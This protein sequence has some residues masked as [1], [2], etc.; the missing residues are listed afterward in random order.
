M[1]GSKQGEAATTPGGKMAFST[2]QKPSQ[3]Q[4]IRTAEI[5]PFAGPSTSSATVPAASNSSSSSADVVSSSTAVAAAAPD[6]S[7]TRPRR[8]MS[9]ASALVAD[10]GGGAP[11]PPSPTGSSGPLS[12]ASG[13]RSLGSMGTLVKCRFGKCVYFSA[14][15]GFC[16]RHA[17]REKAEEEA[18]LLPPRSKECEG[19]LVAARELLTT[20]RSY[21]EALRTIQKAFRLRL[22]VALE[23]HVAM[24]KA[25]LCTEDDIVKIFGNVA[26]LLAL[27]ESL[28]ADLAAL[29]EN[30]R[31]VEFSAVV[32]A[33][34]IPQFQGVYIV[35]LEG[36]DESRRRLMNLRDDN[37]DFNKFIKATEKSE[38]L[39]LDS[40]LVTPVQ[41]LPRSARRAPQQIQHHEIMLSSLC[42][43]QTHF[44]F[45]CVFSRFQILA[46]AEGVD[47]SYPSVSF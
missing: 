3:T 37:P 13:A 2:L 16:L 26:A 5:P 32:L 4:P 7:R 45:L 40:F 38:G 31:S 25:P 27:S 23:M 10:F 22:E 12:P 8:A 29:A 28:Y 44:S 19:Q 34:Y 42:V 43:P 21:L 20:E 30:D 33:H 9:D 46:I 14:R 1:P 41:R 17:W 18:A 15:G 47:P 24:G 11:V 36:F 39:S 35:Y 6:E